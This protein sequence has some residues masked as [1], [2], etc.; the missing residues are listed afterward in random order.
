MLNWIVWINWIFQNRNIFDCELMLN[1]FFE[2]E[3]TIRIK[4][5]LAL[6]N[7]QNQPTTKIN[8]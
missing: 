6:N 5:D 2:I 4:I 7:Q 3:I 8:E 1:W